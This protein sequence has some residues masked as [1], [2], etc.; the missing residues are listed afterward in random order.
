MDGGKP[1][2]TKAKS[3]CLLAVLFCVLLPLAAWAEEAADPTVPPT[4][5]LRSARIRAVGDV[6]AHDHQL[7]IAKQK[8]GSYDFHPQLSLIADALGNA[9]YT[10]ANL[11]TTI[12]KCRGQGYSGY[13]SFNSP[14]ALLDALK[15]AGVDF[16]TLANNHMLDR[17]LEGVLNTVGYVEAYGFDHGGANRSLEE[18]ARPV[19]AEVNGIRI[20]FI[21]ETRYTNSQENY[22]KPEDR[23]YAINYL[24]AG[25]FQEDLQ[26]LKDENVDVIIAIPH[27]GEE[28]MRKPDQK[29]Q[30]IARAMI[31]MGVDVILGSHPHVAQP[32]QML[33]VK[34]EDGQ[35]R[36]GLVAYSM[37][38]FLSNQNWR[39]A[40]ASLMVDFTL[41]EKQGGG[42]EV[43][44]VGV[45]PLYICNTTKMVCTVSA[46]KYLEHPHEA[47]D[48]K[49]VKD[50]KQA[51][52][53]L[54]KLID[55]RVPFLAE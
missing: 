33:T 16:L 14:R 38:N 6:M 12:G 34:G 1:M 20:G 55:E 24:R 46:Q 5:P 40:N 42:F 13:P 2:I 18:K 36:T 8:D 9:D 50:M 22:L 37:G 7:K 32:I 10:I 52:G 49:T 35:E 43:K 31:A 27:W 25:E 41:Q 48:A 30:Q 39:Y 17:R 54:R 44:N 26:R 51:Y 23:E 53:D 11:E 45:I 15:D 21:C 28:Y 47:M 3:L 19:I 29:T 4:Q